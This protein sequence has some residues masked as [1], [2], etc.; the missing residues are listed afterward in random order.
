MDQTM[1]HA[2]FRFYAELNDFL[3]R[4]RRSVTFTHSFHGSASIKDRIEA[5]GVPHTEVDL[6]LVNGESVDFSYRVR[7]GDR[8]SVYPVFESIDITPVVRVRPQPLREPRFVLDIHLGRLAGYLRMLGFDS[9]YRNDYTDAELARVS[10]EEHRI[11]LTRDRGLLKR[12]RVTHGYCLRE[13]H[14]PR[15]QLAEVLRRFDLFNAMQP[16]RRCMR[17]NDL[18][19]PVSRD[20]VQDRLPPLTREHYEEFH[21]CASCDRIYWKGSHYDRMRAFID[22]LVP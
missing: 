3:P 1:T 9:V 17:C 10:S 22:A 8:I 18:L 16:F 15:R 12:S 7:D 4:E 14:S 2:H 21:R 19:H 5:L 6:I 13:I 11:L 20:A